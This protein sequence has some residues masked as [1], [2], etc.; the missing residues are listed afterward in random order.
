M[1]L[2][3]RTKVTGRAAGTQ[4]DRGGQQRA[5]E[6]GLWQGFAH[7]LQGWQVL[8]SAQTFLGQGTTAPAVLAGANYGEDK[9]LCLITA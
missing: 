1:F 3:T 8:C 7:H 5:L 2:F 9:T 6:F 4:L